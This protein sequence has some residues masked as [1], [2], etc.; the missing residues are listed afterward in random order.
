[1]KT[2]SLLLFLL[3]STIVQAQKLQIYNNETDQQLIAAT[4]N[5]LWVLARNAALLELDKNGKLLQKHNAQNGLPDYEI[6]K[7]QELSTNKFEV[8][9]SSEEFF[10]L[11]NGLWKRKKIK[12]GEQPFFTDA[13]HGVVSK[14]QK[15]IELESKGKAYKFRSKKEPKDLVPNA[16]VLDEEEQLWYRTEEAI[17]HYE[18]GKQY[19]IA[20]SEYGRLWNKGG[21]LMYYN[22]TDVLIYSKSEDTW[23]KCSSQACQKMNR[24]VFLAIANNDLWFSTPTRDTLFSFDGINFQRHEL[25]WTAD[26]KPIRL[27]AFS[28]VTSSPST[29][30][31]YD[32]GVPYF[33]TDRN[34]FLEYD[35]GSFRQIVLYDEQTAKANKAHEGVKVLVAKEEHIWTTN[36]SFV[37]YQN[38]KTGTKREWSKANYP[39][40]NTFMFL[41]MTLEQ[42]VA[43]TAGDTTEVWQ[44]LAGL[45]ATYQIEVQLKDDTIKAA[46]YQASIPAVYWLHQDGLQRTDSEGNLFYYQVEGLN[47]TLYDWYQY[48]EIK[49]D[50]KGNSWQLNKRENTTQSIANSEYVVPIYKGQTW[51]QDP[52]QKVWV[53]SDGKLTYIDANGNQKEIAALPTP[54][55]KKYRAT[56]IATNMAEIVATPAGVLYRGDAAGLYYQW[57]NKQWRPYPIAYAADTLRKFAKSGL[58]YLDNKQHLWILGEGE[59]WRVENGLATRIATYDKATTS[60]QVT[61][62]EQHNIW[63]A[64]DASLLKYS[65]KK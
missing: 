20:T 12:R 35:N 21:K 11:E 64:T 58:L 57:Q 15:K 4:S 46:H 42:I 29:S 31:I 3:L 45:E 26:G 59:I 63:I 16:F 39:N 27:K 36:G 51:Y 18:S 28:T 10:E 49:W 56:S 30:R 60:L 37:S 22:G 25:P 7:M 1:M 61:E 33:T 62:D 8:Y 52:T 9:T 13:L 40:P 38:T 44:H 19:P 54:S 47:D 14:K 34:N 2:P 55:S 50:D 65:P 23:Q 41:T 53:V 32:N 5:R 24:C 17:I 48:N 43:A 6:R